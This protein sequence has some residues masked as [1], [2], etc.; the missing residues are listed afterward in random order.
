MNRTL[1]SGHSIRFEG[2][3]TIF[4]DVNPGAQVVAAGNIV[5]L[6]ALKGV[7]HAGAT[8]D[9]DTFIL[10]FDLQPTQL[11]IARK[12]AIVPAKGNRRAIDPEI[13]VIRNEHIVIEPYRSR[14]PR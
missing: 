1:R 3:V 12:I 8:G 5:V 4:G 6:G 11:R 13:A 7:A 14:L 10:A 9:E 2:D